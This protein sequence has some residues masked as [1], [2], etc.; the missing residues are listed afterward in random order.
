MISDPIECRHLVGKLSDVFRV[1][2]RLPDQVFKATYRNYAFAEFDAAMS[3]EFW[4]VI[5]ELLRIAN[6]ES[7]LI[8][9]LEPDPETYFFK[10]FGGYNFVELDKRASPTDYWNALESGPDGSPADAILYNSEVV[11]WVPASNDWVIWGQRDCGVCV[12]GT[13]MDGDSSGIVSNEIWN[14]VDN[15]IADLLP[16]YFHDRKIPQHFVLRLRSS[17]AA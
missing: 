14:S 16:A 13:N 7:I 10:Q 15:A 17:Y 8:A 6:A 11:V 2:N 1:R 9:V 12:L 4:P 3:A 5:Q